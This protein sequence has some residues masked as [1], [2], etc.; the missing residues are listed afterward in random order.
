M[1]RL[2]E[3]VLEAHGGIDPWRATTSLTARIRLGGPFWAGRGWPDGFDVSVTLATRREH[4]SITYAD[5]REAV[6]D[7]AP[8][9]LTLRG[10]DGAILDTRERPR[11][12]FP[13]PFDPFAT[14]WDAMQVA[15]FQATANWNYLTEPWQFAD[16]ATTTRELE[17][18]TDPGGETWR[19]LHVTF[20]PSNANHNAEQVFYFGTG[21][22]ILRRMDYSPDV[23]GNR[24]IAHYCHDPVTVNGFTFPT[25]RRVHPRGADGVAD[26]DVTFIAID[27]SEL[28]IA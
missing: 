22:L 26:R 16:P 1:G 20:P 15:Y 6:F 4:I 11:A 3:D 18:W 12:S 19:R 8:E 10:P 14:P 17:R 21:D 9:R 27:V 13:L 28:A 25:R 7:V 24:L 23:T 2:L 5:Q